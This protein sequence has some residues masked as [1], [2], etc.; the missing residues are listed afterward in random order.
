MTSIVPEE[1]IAPANGLSNKEDLVQK[2]MGRRCGIV[3]RLVTV[4]QSLILGLVDLSLN[5]DAARSQATR[6]FKSENRIAN[7]KR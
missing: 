1:S 5:L 4:R 7:I 2:E 3:I 6:D